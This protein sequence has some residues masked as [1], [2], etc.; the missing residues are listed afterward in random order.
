MLKMKFIPLEITQNLH[1]TAQNGNHGN[2]KRRTSYNKYSSLQLSFASF[3]SF[4]VLLYCF[5][6]III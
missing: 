1:T 2:H 5:S 6:S 3:D 4:L